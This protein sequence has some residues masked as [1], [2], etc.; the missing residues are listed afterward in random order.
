MPVLIDVLIFLGAAL[1]VYNIYGF[2]SY[3][4]YIKKLNKTSSET[5]F[6]QVPII[7]LV[8]FLLGYLFVGFFG[9]P[10][11]VMAGILFG[12][13]IFVYT[14]YSFLN[15][16]TKLVLETDKLEAQLQAER[17]HNKTKNNFLSS[18]SHEMRNPMNV[19]L[20][21]GSMVLKNE[22]LDDDAREKVEKMNSASKHILD[23]INNI[24]ELNELE[25]GELQLKEEKFELKEAIKKI[26]ANIETLC[27]KKGLEYK[28]YL[29]ENACN[30]YIGDS[31][32]LRQILLTFLDN[33][34]KYTDVPGKVEFNINKLES[35]EDVDT[36][37]FV[38]KDTGVGIDEEF[39]PK[40][41]DSFAQ[42]DNS[43]TNKGGGGLGLSVAKGLADLM[44]GK[45]IVESKKNEGS[46]FKLIVD[47]RK[48]VE[49]KQEADDD[50][51]NGYKILVAEDIDDN[52][53]I[54]LDLLETEGAEGVRAKNGK[55]ALEMYA[56]SDINYYDAVLMDLRMPEMDGLTATKEIRN[57]NR[58]DAKTVPIIALTANALEEDVE[59]SLS[60]GMNEHLVKPIDAD[61]LF[62]TLKDE[63]RK[64]EAYD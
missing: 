11:I 32:K 46:T 31:L 17:E 57:L 27:R 21:L 9:N 58:K 38:V 62:R 33:A 48:D 43:S 23:L 35:K 64:K 20:G 56:N 51:L 26:N 55:E 42:E 59:N 53:E 44:N 24:L 25:T 41:F 14:M 7:L 39:I 10:D 15:R 22:S 49:V 12:G 45:I 63:I 6:L 52:A 8:L 3:T 36:I 4:K 18:M 28:C 13:S 37:E 54:V 61:L 60:V 1:M 16:V 47:L 5:N 2:I 50:I 30:N 29:D 40:I 19:V 34:M